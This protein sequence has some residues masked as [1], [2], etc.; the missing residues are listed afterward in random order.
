MAKHI[1]VID[2]ALDLLQLLSVFLEEEGYEVVLSATPFHQVAEVEQIH[3][4]LIILDI[5]FGQ[6]QTG[7]QMLDALRSNRSTSGIPVVICSAALL[8]V[9]KQEDSLKEQGIP[10]VYKPFDIDVLL[11]TI[12]TL[13]EKPF[14]LC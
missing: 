8:R 11:D 13:L 14:P 10:V 1:L 3:P 2:D 9:Q 5:V 6:E 4:D 12:R 7:W